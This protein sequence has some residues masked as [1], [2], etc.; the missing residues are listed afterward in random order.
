MHTTYI[1]KENKIHREENLIQT[2]TTHL[3]LAMP[4]SF[5][6]RSKTSSHDRLL[7]P[8]FFK[9]KNPYF[10]SKTSSTTQICSQMHR[11]RDI[12]IEKEMKNPRVQT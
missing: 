4:T 6:I 1:C 12:Q 7:D 3:E 8:I 5:L 9:G 10:I 2:T 11:E